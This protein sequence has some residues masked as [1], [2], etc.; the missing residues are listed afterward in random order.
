MRRGIRRLKYIKVVTKASGRRYVY[1]SQ[2]GK[3]RVALP[4]L[5]END[6]AFLA[7][8]VA[9][10][11][12][13]EPVQRGAAKAGTIG[14]LIISYKRSQDYKALKG[15]TQQVRGRILDKIA[16][17]GGK[18]LVAGLKT[19]HIKADIS[20]LAPHAANNRLKVW[21]TL[22]DQAIED[23][24]IERNPARDVKKVA[25]S[26]VGHHCWTDDEIAIY[27][28]HHANGTKAR[29]AFELLLWTGAR[30][31]DAVRLGRQHISNG[32]LTY[33]SQKTSVEVCIPVLPEMQVEIGL[34]PRTQMLFLETSRGQPHSNKAFGAWFGEQC[35]AARLPSRCTAHGLRKARAR[36]MAEAGKTA[37]QIAAWGG[38]KTL[39]E[40]AHYTE[41]VD[42]KRLTHENEESA[43]SGNRAEPVSNSGE[44]ISNSRGVC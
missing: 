4:N 25:A 15:S 7:A 40:V 28:A 19:K 17:K 22:L 32:S 30:R 9:A 18:A 23:E 14:A 43:F 44:K 1:Y 29:L 6:P 42:R 26:T 27:R 37:H 21:R 16:T 10:Q 12:G 35:R 5:H 36:I 20:A 24:L 38:W 39:S 31:G 34:M 11:S 41:A 13:A 3:Q 33:V 8:Y 2:P